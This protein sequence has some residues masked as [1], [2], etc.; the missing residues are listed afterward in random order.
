MKEGWERTE[1]PLELSLEELNQIVAPAFPGREIISSRRIGVGLSNS[2]YKIQIEGDGRPYV[3]RFF[4]RGADI[5][6]KEIAL[7]RLVRERVP[8]AEFVYAD[9]SCSRYPKPWAVL[10]WKPGVLLS[11]II[12]EGTLE[13]KASAAA[14]AGRTL[15]HIHGFPFEASG[16]FGSDLKVTQPFSMSGERFLA[17]MDDVIFHSPCEAWLG[18][19][20]SRELWAFCKR[21]GSILSVSQ[22]K[23]VLAHSDYNG[24]NILMEKGSEGYFVSAVLDWE[25]AFAWNRYADLG[26]MLRYEANGSWIEQHFIKAYEAEGM[27]LEKNWRLLSRLEDL[28]ALCDMLSHSTAETPNRVQDLCRLIAGTVRDGGSAE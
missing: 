18:D 16:F 15:A 27:V 21:Y 22:E 10:E 6:G 11:D 17:F 2:N 25:E 23:I 24:L 7:T 28:V 19:E 12:R 13:E 4:R 9:T 8:V 3:L 20:L 1:Q 14:A 26:N 5:A